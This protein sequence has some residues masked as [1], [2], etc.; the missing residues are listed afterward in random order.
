MAHNGACPDNEEAS[1]RSFAHLRDGA[2]PLLAAGRL[3][4]RREA[5]PGCQ[6]TPGR[7]RLDRRRQ[8]GYRSGGDGTHTWYGHQPASNRV[9]FG[10]TADLDI[11]NRDVLFQRREGRDEHSEDR[12]GAFRQRAVRV[13]DLTDQRRLMRRAPGDNPAI[14][15]KVPSERV[16]ALRTLTDQHV[17][18]PEYHTVRLLRFAFH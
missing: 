6:V 2:E 10:A 16:D 8:R 12:T 14:L 13:F 5:Q 1:Y 15:G 4:Q 18:R 9:F 3:L 7:K 11:Q 17:T